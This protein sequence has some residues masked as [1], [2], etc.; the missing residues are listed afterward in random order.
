MTS[1]FIAAVFATL[2]LLLA[3][4]ALA[5]QFGVGI[6][7]A[8]GAADGLDENDE[9]SFDTSAGEIGFLLDTNRDK[10]IFNYRLLA[11]YT[12]GEVDDFEVDGFGP[13]PGASGDYDGFMATNTFHFRVAGNRTVDFSLGPSVYLGVLNLEDD[14]DDSD[15]FYFGLGP[16]AALDIRL[17]DA[18]T[19]ALELAFR[20]GQVAV[21]DDS[22]EDDADYEVSELV[23]RAGLLFGN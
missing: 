4:P 15:G 17:G 3:Q 5:V 1:R 16:T 6:A 14:T 9:L 13:I 21:D 23:L 10:G 19:L 22:D 2:A 20:Y 7:A 12:D 11:A 18:V 8:G